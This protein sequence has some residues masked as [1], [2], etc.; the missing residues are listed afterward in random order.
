MAETKTGS[1][2]RKTDLLTAAAA[3]FA[4]RGYLAVGVDEIGERA[5][6]TGSAL[7][8]HFDCKEAVLAAVILDA[9]QR[10]AHI[11]EVAILTR[12]GD[13]AR[14]LRQLLE[15]TTATALASGD[16]AQVYVREMS[17]LRVGDRLAVREADERL[18]QVVRQLMLE[19]APGLT[20][21][22]FTLRSAFVSGAVAAVAREKALLPQHALQKVV[23][24]STF[25]VLRMPAPPIAREA[26]MAAATAP[27]MPRPTRR[28]EI[29]AI[30][31]EL[32]AD[33]DYYA[34]SMEDI[35]AAAGISA[36]AIYRHFDSKAD[37][38]SE[39]IVRVGSRAIVGMERALR[40]AST[41]FEALA[42]LVH[43]LA[44]EAVEAG[45]LLVV[46]TQ[47][48]QELRQ[49]EAARELRSRRQMLDTWTHVIRTAR[50]ELKE[51]HAR[52]L[53]RAGIAGI[54]QAAQI[55]RP[56]P[57]QIDELAELALTLLRS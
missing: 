11:A 47:S 8:N 37:I 25:A 40:E 48:L 49:E 31:A 9:A 34:V 46:L 28:D 29:L 51:A 50:P 18:L 23:A 5:G 14:D 41:P 1:K 3:L 10:L 6:I 42:G 21:Q 13:P 20:P 32:F 57:V 56:A 44:R 17:R 53:A 35:G 27:W 52:I 54:A 22:S 2:D 45:F 26:R 12:T 38:V 30:A 19:V 33:R 16:E 7:Y 24:D 36:A 55:A 39:A 15:L 43:S 4:E